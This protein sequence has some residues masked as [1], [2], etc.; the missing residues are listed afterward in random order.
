MPGGT[1]QE[2]RE[3][4]PRFLHG[5][6]ALQESS[7]HPLGFSRAQPGGPGPGAGAGRPGA[8]GR[9]QQAGRERGGEAPA[10]RQGLL[11]S[12]PQREPGTKGQKRQ[13]PRG[14]PSVP[15]ARCRCVHTA[16]EAEAWGAW[17]QAGAPTALTQACS[18]PPAAQGPQPPS[19]HGRPAPHPVS[20]GG[21]VPQ[22]FQD[23][24]GA[25]RARESL[26]CLARVFSSP[27]SP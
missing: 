2:G 23:D 12:R 7:P 6:F 14:R 15:D 16:P 18:H 1:G 24:F 8:R 27:A 20:G 26:C 3:Q 10:G 19:L 4:T 22:I 5:S 21:Q 25:P 17:D 11:D 13:Q 9:R